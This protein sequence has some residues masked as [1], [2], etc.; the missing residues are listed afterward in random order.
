[1][2]NCFPKWLSCIPS[3]NHTYEYLLFHISNNIGV[4][5]CL[6]LFF[7]F[8][9]F[10]KGTVITHCG[11]DI[12]NV[13]FNF[14][15]IPLKLEKGWR[16]QKCYGW[17]KKKKKKKTGSLAGRNIETFLWFRLILQV[18]RVWA[19]IRLCFR[20]RSLELSS[21]DQRGF[22]SPGEQGMSGEPSQN[23]LMSLNS[24]PGSLQGMELQRAATWSCGLL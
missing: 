10:N 3:S 11:S 15:P 17:F 1:M 2:S 20:G 8:S 19:H 5:I 4:V 9:P 21:R 23:W 14:F 7:P 16:V 6:Y 12:L 18:R 22:K 13:G 24:T